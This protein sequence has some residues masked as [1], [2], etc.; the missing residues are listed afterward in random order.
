MDL[1][2]QSDRTL[3]AIRMNDWRIGVDFPAGR[4]AAEARLEAD[5]EITTGSL[6]SGEDVTIGFETD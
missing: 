4:D 6:S 5:R 1:P 2:I 3:D